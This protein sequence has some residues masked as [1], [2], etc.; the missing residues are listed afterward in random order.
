VLAVEQRGAW[1]KSGTVSAT[2][3][4]SPSRLSQ[5]MIQS[6]DSSSFISS[7]VCAKSSSRIGVKPQLRLQAAL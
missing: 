3:I 1:L 4:V 2:A 7:A 6:S 5:A